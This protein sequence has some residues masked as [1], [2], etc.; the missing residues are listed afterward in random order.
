MQQS[1]LG[2]AKHIRVYNI[3]FTS[4]DLRHIVNE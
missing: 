1:V 3:N 4:M 2:K